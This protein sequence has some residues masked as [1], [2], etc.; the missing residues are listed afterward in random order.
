MSYYNYFYK[1]SSKV[2]VFISFDYDHDI[3]LKN[4]L[5]GQAKNEDSPFEITDMSVKE[6][7]TGDWKE[8]VRQRIKRVDQVIIICGEHTDSASDV[9]AEL[10]ITQEEGKPYFLLWGRSDKNCVKPKTAKDND[11]IYKW[12]W[13]NL[14]RLLNGER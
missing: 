9:A 7:L 10:K 14:K 2:R 5:V 11:K 8:K 6:E 1:S 3:D 12:T 4:L 13:D